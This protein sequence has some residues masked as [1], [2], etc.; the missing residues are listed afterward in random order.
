MYRV[1]QFE[2]DVY[3]ANSSTGFSHVGD[4]SGALGL[5]ICHVSDGSDCHQLVFNTAS[6]STPPTDQP[7]PILIELGIGSQVVII[8]L[9]VVVMIVSCF[10]CAFVYVYRKNKLIKTSQ[11]EMLYIVNLGCFMMGVRVIVGAS[12][13]SD[14]TC[15][16]GL[17]LGHV[18]FWLV[19]A[20]LCLKSWRIHRIINNKTLVRVKITVHD[21][22]KR[23]AAVMSLV[24]LYLIVLTV[25][26]EPHQSYIKETVSNQATHHITCSSHITA[27][28]LVLYIIEAICVV[29]GAELSYATKDVPGALN[30]SKSIAQ[31]K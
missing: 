10:F 15:V 23:F 27:F 31:C 3:E 30:E 17:W 22:L 2:A 26:A 24:V 20:T 28:E 8:F 12:P 19:F 9:G 5:D 18:A 14:G 6:G 29:F 11:P 25:V 21:I 4:W 1:M 13:I 7:P 16:A